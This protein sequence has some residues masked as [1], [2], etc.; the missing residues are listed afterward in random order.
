[1]EAMFRDGQFA[2]GV[3]AG[4]AAIN[5]LLTQHFPRHGEAGR[6]ELPDRPL[7]LP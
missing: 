6:N 1:M 4:I 3:E 2:V 5:A 7:I